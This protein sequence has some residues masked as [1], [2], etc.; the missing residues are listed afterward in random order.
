MLMIT[1]MVL[2]DWF[3]PDVTDAIAAN[4]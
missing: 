2:S 4:I 1:R 3:D